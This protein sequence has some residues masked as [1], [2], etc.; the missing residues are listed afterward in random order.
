MSHIVKRAGHKEPY[1]QK[2]VYASVYAA[3]MSLRVQQQE[4]ELI[5]EKVTGEI[6]EIIADK[7]EVT[8]HQ[9]FVEISSSL[10]RLNPEAAFLYRTHMDVS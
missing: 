1:D 9:L 10:E 6:N 7:S 8:S 2:K 3:C 5:A 4:A